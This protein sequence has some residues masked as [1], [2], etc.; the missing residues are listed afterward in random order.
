MFLLVFPLL[1]GGTNSAIYIEVTRVNF[2]LLVLWLLVGWCATPLLIWWRFPIP[3]P[4]DPGPGPGEP[5][6]II[7]AIGVVGGLIGGWLFILAFSRP[8]IW[9]VIGPH[10]EP[11]IPLISAAATSIG[12]F[13]GSRIAVDIYGLIRG[14]GR[15][16]Q[17]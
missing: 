6:P 5:W 13:I 16:T 14:A 12:A 4:G 9:D 15:P 2:Q 17:G 11:W 1:S 8:E 10:S 7:K 3:G